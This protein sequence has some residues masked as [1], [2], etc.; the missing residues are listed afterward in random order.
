MI[1]L[2]GYRRFGHNEQDEAAYTQPLMV[3]Q[4]DD[5]PSV[6]ELYQ[7]AARRGRA[8]SPREEAEAFVAEVESVLRGAHD[9]LRASF[10]QEAQ[11]EYDGVVPRA[12]SVEVSTALAADKLV[13]LNEQLLRTPEEF[14]VHPKLARQLE[15]RRTA[16]AEGGIDWGHAESLAYASLLVDGI[17]IRLTGQ[18]SQRGTFSQ[19]HLVLHD[20]H[21]GETVHADA[22]PRRGPGRRSRSSTRRSPS[23]RASAS[24]T[25]TRRRR[26]RRSSSGR[27]STAT[28]RTARRS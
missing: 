11:I 6:R 23:T 3:E 20:V 16:I 27:P 25:A 4:I 26:P 28:S 13:E 2:V 8:C 24:S 14:T 18:D 17:P 22:A 10:D 1:D 15:R 12:T 21:T 7:A 5:H 19:R 9:R